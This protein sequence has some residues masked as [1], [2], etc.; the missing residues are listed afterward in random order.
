MAEEAGA[1]S[2]APTASRLDAS[3]ASENFFDASA[4][5][6]RYTNPDEQNSVH[7]PRYTETLYMDPGTRRPCT[8]TPNICHRVWLIESRRPTTMCIP[9]GRVSRRT[10]DRP[11]A[12]GL[13]Q[14]H[15]GTSSR[16]NALP[17]ARP[18]VFELWDHAESPE[19]KPGLHMSGTPDGHQGA[20]G[21]LV[22]AQEDEP[23]HAD[24]GRPRD[25]AREQTAEEEEEEE[26]DKI[27]LWGQQQII[28]CTCERSAHRGLPRGERVTL[29]PR[30]QSLRGREG[31]RERERERE[32][33]M[34]EGEEEGKRAVSGLSGH[35]GSTW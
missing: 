12:A 31:E 11:P 5:K 6:P 7:G 26:E 23:A 32:R 2:H 8:W 35:I 19:T 9:D 22:G 16:T 15:T 3:D 27:T 21:L 10:S 14:W 1:I 28:P 18:A 29:P 4:G 17:P 24:E 34:K 30:P 20:A 25:A 33:M 13:H